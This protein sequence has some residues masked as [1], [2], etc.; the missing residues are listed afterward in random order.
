MPY[1]L[2]ADWVIHAL[3]G[4]RQAVETLKRLAPD[5]IAISWVTIGE[6]YEGAFGFPDPAAHLAS[7]RRF[8]QPFRI[9]DLDDPIMER[10]AELRS[11]LRRQGEIIPDFDILIG[12]TA[13]H[14]NL[15]VL[16]DNVRHFQRIPGLSLY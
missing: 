6:V 5:G 9:L 14:H 4:R 7:F 8:L 12:A 11:L 15:T 16:T 3:A 2:D 13:L 1:L 10:F